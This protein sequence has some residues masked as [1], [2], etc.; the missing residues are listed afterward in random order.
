MKL[1]PIILLVVIIISQ[2]DFNKL[3]TYWDNFNFDQAYSD[4]MNLCM[5]GETNLNGVVVSTRNSGDL[6]IDKDLLQYLDIGRP[7]ENEEG[8]SYINRK[9]QELKNTGEAI[10]EFRNKQP[11]L[12]KI[13]R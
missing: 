7:F 13:E 5:I 3:C 1:L 8:H 12:V 2:G 11:I 10:I 4:F 9:I 6:N